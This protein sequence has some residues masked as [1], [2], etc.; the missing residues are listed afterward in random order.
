MML[1]LTKTLKHQ[2]GF[3]YGCTH[4]IPFLFYH[5]HLISA[6]LYDE[7]HA[8]PLISAFLYDEWF[9]THLSQPFCMMPMVAYP[10]ISA[11]L[12]DEW[13]PTHLSQPFCM[14][15]GCLPAYLSLSV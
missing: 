3:E 5:I 13:L 12:Y 7:W 14:M 4:N 9:P 2:Q 11:F 6:F 8:Y 1:T 10:L 15:N